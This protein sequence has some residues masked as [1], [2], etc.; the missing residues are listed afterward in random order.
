MDILNN[1]I[2]KIKKDGHKILFITYFGSHLYGTNTEKS[3]LDFRGVYLPSLKSLILSKAPRHYSFTTSNKYE[4]N[5]SKDCDIQMWSLHFFLDKVRNG[6]TNAIDLLFAPTNKNTIVYI[7][8]KYLNLIFNNRKKFVTKNISSFIG[9][10]MQQAKKYGIKGS[11]L[12]IIYTLI[13]I[14]EDNFKNKEDYSLL[15]IKDVKTDLFRLL[16]P[17]EF[18]KPIKMQIES[19][20]N[21]K[22]I[23]GIYIIGKKFQDHFKLHKFYEFLI[24]Y[25]NDYGQRAKLA[26]ENKGIDWK[27]LSHAVRCILQTKKLLKYG[28]IV[29]PFKENEKK[30]LLNIKEGK[31]TFQ[32]VSDIINKGIEE[33]KELKQKTTLKEKIN[34]K[35]I[36]N[37]ILKFYE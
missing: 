27:A 22:E 8:D 19:K 30:L 13:K 33:I 31:L 3:D 32:E 28:E 11:R 7:D 36:E 25:Y 18:W 5:T 37:T 15:T 9:Y 34:N 29:F 10:I 6:E 4:K 24:K 12:G 21:I 14:I 23:G 26:M 35:F 16:N 17:N 1:F 20:N 2:A